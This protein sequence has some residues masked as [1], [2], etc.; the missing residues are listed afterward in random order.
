MRKLLASTLEEVHYQVSVNVV[1]DEKKI[2]TQ[3]NQI[4]GIANNIN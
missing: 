4:S 1:L 3:N 2:M